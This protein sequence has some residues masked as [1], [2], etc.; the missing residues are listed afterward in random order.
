M[1]RPVRTNN[2]IA[3]SSGD[4]GAL[5]SVG[6]RTCPASRPAIALVVTTAHRVR[7]PTIGCRLFG[8]SPQW[9]PI[10]ALLLAPNVPGGTGYVHLLRGAG[11]MDERQA[12]CIGPGCTKRRWSPR[13]PRSLRRRVT[14]HQ[15]TAPVRGR[16]GNGFRYSGTGWRPNV[17]GLSIPACR[18]GPCHRGQHF[19]TLVGVAQPSGTMPAGARSAGPRWSTRATPVRLACLWFSSG[20][21]QPAAWSRPIRLPKTPTASNTASMFNCM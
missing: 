10:P 20:R 12:R 9:E 14:Q 18:D 5:A 19:S 1:L 17:S 13:Q 11:S 21:Q 15:Q 3:S 8:F 16:L 6:P 7:R 4:N 2:F